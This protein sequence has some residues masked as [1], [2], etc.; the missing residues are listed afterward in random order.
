MYILASASPRRRE[1]LKLA[2]EKFEI[3]PSECEETVPENIPAEKRPE[4]LACLKAGDIAAKYPDDTVIGADTMVFADGIVLGKPR[5]REDAVRMLRLLSGSTHK[6]VTGCAVCEKGICRSFSS[7]TEVTFY[8]LRDADI[9][10]Y[11]DTS[12]PYDKAGGYG[13]Q[14]SGTLFVKEI[15]GDYFIVVGLPVAALKRFLYN[16]TP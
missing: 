15:K 6:V 2:V 14:G 16:K 9:E 4:Y 1:L 5:D 7:V 11:A 10:A 13:I 12:E 8:D 3:L